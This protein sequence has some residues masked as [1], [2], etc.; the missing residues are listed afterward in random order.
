MYPD[1]YYANER[2]FRVFPSVVRAGVESTLTVVSDMAS[3]P[4]L[5]DMVYEVRFVPKD[6]RENE[7]ER[8]FREF[9]FE[10]ICPMQEVTVQNGKIFL[11]YTFTGEHERLIYLKKKEDASAV[12]WFWGES[13]PKTRVRLSVYSLSEEL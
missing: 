5:D 6:G 3:H 13:M 1:G 7:D 10:D 4:L 12:E 2:L 11:H 8:T 9:G